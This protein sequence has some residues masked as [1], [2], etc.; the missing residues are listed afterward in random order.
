MALVKTVE[1]RILANAGDAQA[2]L[3]ELNAK[4]KELDGNAIKMRFRLDDADGKAQ[5]DAIKAKAERLGFKDVVIKVRVDGAGRAIGELQAVKAEEDRVRGS[6]L[7]RIGGS[8]F[9]LGPGGTGAG[10]GTLA[11]LSPGILAGLAAAVPAAEALLVELT[12]IVSGFAA[13]GAGAGAFYVLAHPAINNLM[14]DIKALG[15]ANQAAGF[16]QQKAQLDP[17]KANLQAAQNAQLRYQAIYRQM[18]ADAG[19]AAAGALKLH[20][21]FVKLTTAFQPQVFKILGDGISILTHLLPA[22]VPLATAFAKA[23][24]P[25][26]KQADR[27]VQSKGF[28]DWLK[29][30]TSLVGPSVTAIGEG[31]GKVAVAFGK[32]LTTMNAADV[33]KSIGIAF[34]TVAAIISGT[35]AVVARLM[36]NW[37]QMSSA[38]KHAASDVVAAFKGMAAGISASWATAIAVIG[39]IPGKIKGFFADAGSWLVQA[40]RNIIMGLVHGIE[41]MIGAVASAIG[42]VVSKI[43]S[44]LPFSPA[45]EG[46]LSGAGSPD[47]A[48]RKVAEM[49]AAGM[50]AGLAGVVAA[51]ARLAAAARP[52]A[53]ADHLEHLHHLH[54]EHEE[55][56]AHLAHLKA[57]EVH[58]HL[59]VHGVVTDAQAV[60]LQIVKV[61]KEYK[62]HGG[63]AAL[64]LG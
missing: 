4:A 52:D 51:A 31:V 53:H 15:A 55:H 3:D 14:G 18:G 16:A 17:T 32:L 10:P 42:G 13:A 26:L 35:A 57:E 50:N 9:G 56:L 30:F 38:A 33:A 44:F 45:R 37:D 5:L 19:P 62:R 63:G 48:G 6:L 58:V 59:D 20:D 1:M 7:N 61:L 36:S 21:A 34:N 23:L 12:G 27:F 39:A 25:L 54:V 2:K 41:S 60:G 29:Q 49:L 64:G 28:A 24:D 47:L 8:F 40:G 43:R 22:A 46:P 11:G